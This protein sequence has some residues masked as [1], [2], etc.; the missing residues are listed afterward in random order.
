MKPERPLRDVLL[1]RHASAGSRLDAL[2][3]TA[4]PGAPIPAGPSVLRDLFFPHRTAWR[5][6]AA[7]WIALLLFHFTLG[8]PPPKITPAIDPAELTAWLN[9][10]KTRETFAHSDF[11]R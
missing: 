2:R 7:V 11:R 6:L 9:Q 1:S 4:L 3:R 10:L 5:T 8:R